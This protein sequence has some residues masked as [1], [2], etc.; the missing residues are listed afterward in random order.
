MSNVMSR[1]SLEKSAKSPAQRGADWLVSLTQPDGSLRGETNIGDYY[2]TVL[3][4][5]AAGRQ[6]ESEKMLNYVVRRFL[7]DDGDLDGTGCEWFDQYRIYPH[8]WLLMAAVVRARF[9]IARRLAGFLEAFQ[10]PDNGGFYGTRADRERRAEQELMTTSAAGIALLWAGRLDAALHAGQWVRRLYEA[11]PDVSRGLYVVWNRQSG[12]VTEFPGGRAKEYLVDAAQTAQYY[13]QYGIA[14]AL[15][16][17]LGGA[18]GERAWLELGHKYLEA[19]KHCQ[20]D[21][22][23]QGTSGKIGW[24][25]T[26]MYRL[27]GDAA[28]RT[29]A[30]AVY[31]SLR[32]TQHADGWWQGGDIYSKASM[33]K[34]DD[35]DA[36]SEFTVFLSWMEDALIDRGVMNHV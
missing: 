35:I 19:T 14:A 3:A 28:D 9:D 29:L 6:N 30:E 2:K 24:G 23:R 10:D 33:P 13:F 15:C 34:P 20:P 8:A 22:Y 21:V 11:Q 26:W 17:G 7:R 32:E 12:L 31:A 5:A 36:T 27:T 18:T 25:A 16:A 4:L 1:T